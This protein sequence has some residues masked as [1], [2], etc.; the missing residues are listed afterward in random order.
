MKNKIAKLYRI[1]N[2]NRIELIK[3]ICFITII[4]KFQ[5]EICFCR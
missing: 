3:D 1:S 4:M 2:N 5:I